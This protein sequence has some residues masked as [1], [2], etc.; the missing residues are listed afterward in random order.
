MAV[1]VMCSWAMMW[2]APIN[3][4]LAA[5]APKAIVTL[6][7]LCAGL[8]ANTVMMS[9]SSKS[10]TY[11]TVSLLHG[12]DAASLHDHCADSAL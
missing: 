3:M 4:T 8:A 10:S 9:S 7:R 2:D 12:P 11:R 6:R 1:Q 5:V